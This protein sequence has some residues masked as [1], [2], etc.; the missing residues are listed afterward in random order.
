MSYREILD[1]NMCGYLIMQDSVNN[2]SRGGECDNFDSFQSHNLP[3]VT[4]DISMTT[5]TLVPLN[6]GAQLGRM[7]P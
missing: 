6:S 2:R 3:V 1:A 5:I 4:V 7:S